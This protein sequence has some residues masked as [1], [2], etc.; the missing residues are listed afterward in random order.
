MTKTP[1][2]LFDTAKGDEWRSHSERQTLETL[3]QFV[4]FV[5]KHLVTTLTMSGRYTQPA[6]PSK[7]HSLGP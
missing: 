1:R 4:K 3:I 5:K 2:V 7:R 6:P